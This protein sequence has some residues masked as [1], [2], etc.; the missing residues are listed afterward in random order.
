LRLVNLGMGLSGVGMNGPMPP[1]LTR[2]ASFWQR[3]LEKEMLHSSKTP[4]RSWGRSVHERVWE[5][6][7]RTTV[8][9]SGV[10]LIGMVAV[11]AVKVVRV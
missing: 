7:G 11:V 1:A 9:S 3:A 2:S 8:S 5:L 6:I 10:H 4:W